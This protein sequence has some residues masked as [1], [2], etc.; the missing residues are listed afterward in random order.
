MYRSQVVPHVSYQKLTSSADDDVHD[1]VDFIWFFMWISNGQ[2]ASSALLQI[3]AVERPPELLG[4][5]ISQD[6]VII[7][8]FMVEI[9]RIMFDNH[10]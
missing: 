7:K 6:E 5:P 1:V 3:D 2:D 4:G 9:G 10:W 8:W